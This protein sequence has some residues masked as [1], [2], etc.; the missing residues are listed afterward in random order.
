MRVD[1]Y[2]RLSITGDVSQFLEIRMENDGDGNPI[3]IGYTEQPNAATDALV[4]FILKITY[5]GN[6]SPTLQELPNDGVR[7]IYAWDDRATYF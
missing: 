5:D 2:S 3:Y 1:D 4:W 7:F 6:G